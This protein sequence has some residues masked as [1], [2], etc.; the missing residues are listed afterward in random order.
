M[1]MKLKAKTR[2]HGGCRASEKNKFTFYQSKIQL[3]GDANKRMNEEY[4]LLGC[5]AV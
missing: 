2:V 4:Y 5:D 1:I 3:Q